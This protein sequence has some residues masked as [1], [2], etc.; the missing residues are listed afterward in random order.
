[1]KKTVLIID[2]SAPIRFL[3][4][5]MLSKEYNVVSASDGFVAL[6]WL[7]KGN[8]VDC[9]VTDLQMPNINGWE[10]LEYL[11]GSGLYQNIPVVVLSSQPDVE[12][13]NEEAGHKYH[14]VH[15]FVQK[16]FDPMRL[17]ETVGQAINRQLVAIA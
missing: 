13:H 9:I 5:A 2:D 14:N 17:M 8:A 7:A 3:L 10:L 6:T 1:M 16:P 11:S 4:E 12:V 15:A